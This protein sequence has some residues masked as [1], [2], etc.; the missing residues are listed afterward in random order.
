VSG[1]ERDDD[2]ERPKL[3]WSEIDK[4]RDKPR[5]R[6]D[7]EPRPRGAAAEVRARD[8]T[9][10]YLKQKGGAL[11]A[12]H[13][14]G[15]RGEA[16]AKAIRDAQGTPGFAEACR[17]FLR[18]LGPPT[19]ASLCARFLDA[20]DP[21]LVLAGLRGLEGLHD[22][23]QLTASAGLRSQLRTLADDAND[24]VASAAEALL[25]AP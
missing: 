23:G 16:L 11:F 10:Q 18:E 14:V 25:R 22:A 21:E 24:E 4:R 8:A 3:S 20:R 6:A 13:G 2:G 12:K 1:H 9:Q 17:A 15:G 7:R 19:E 5:T